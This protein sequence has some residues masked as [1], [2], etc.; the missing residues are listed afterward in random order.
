MD[1]GFPRRPAWASESGLVG[2]FDALRGRTQAG[3]AP[4]STRC[5]RCRPPR[6][7]CRPRPAS[8]RPARASVCF[9]AAEGPAFAQTQADVVALLDNDDDPDVE[10]H[11]DD[12][13]LHLAASPG[14]EDVVRAGHRP[15]RGQHL[16]GGAGL[17]P[18]AAVLAGRLPRPGRPAARAGLPLQ[19]GH[20]LPVRARPGRPAPRQ[21]ARDPGPRPA[22]DDLPIE[23]TSALDG[24]LGR[25]RALT[26]SVGSAG[27]SRTA[28]S[29]CSP[30]D[31]ACDA[32]VAG[33][34]SVLAARPAG[35]ASA[36]ARPW[37][38]V[39]VSGSTSIWL[40]TCAGDE[41][42]QRPHEVG[43]VDP[44]HRRAV[45]DRLVEEDD[46]LVRVGVRRAAARG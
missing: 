31:G 26:R 35:R 3:A 38:S 7:R 39:S 18:G 30:V 44:V 33:R 43:Q 13:R 45:A 16:A 21:P 6:S 9:R 5:S 28:L 15:A 46:V 22:D 23:P 25:P 8:R 17:R 12:V 11:T 2:I 20:V 36:A 40:T 37:P 10:Q 24:A 1:G 42:L 34:P 27:L 4:T 19:A 29:D 14:S 32:S 41:V